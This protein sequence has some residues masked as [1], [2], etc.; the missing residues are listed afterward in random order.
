VIGL[1]FGASYLLSRLLKAWSRSQVSGRP[2]AYWRCL[3]LVLLVQV[4]ALVPVKVLLYWAF[5]MKYFI[6]LPEYSVNV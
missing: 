2:M 3:L 6:Y 4:A 5:D 1:V